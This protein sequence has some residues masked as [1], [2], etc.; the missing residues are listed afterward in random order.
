MALSSQA[1]T[2]RKAYLGTSPAWGTT[3]PTAALP[4]GLPQGLVR[5]QEKLLPG[6]LPHGEAEQGLIRP[7][8]QAKG[9]GLLDGGPADGQIRNLVDLPID[10][11]AVFQGG[12]HHLIAP[13]GQGVQQVLEILGCQLAPAPRPEEM[14]RS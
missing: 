6:L 3:L 4:L 2:P 14:M 8:F 9:P 11:L 7:W 5:R 10:Q 12:A 1:R 13:G